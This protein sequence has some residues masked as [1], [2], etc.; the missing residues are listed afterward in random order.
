MLIFRPML[1]LFVLL[2]DD[3]QLMFVMGLRSFDFTIVW[4]LFG[5][6]FIFG[7]LYFRK[8]SYAL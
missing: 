8:E 4:S 3:G 5:L 6:L 7:V 1:G 2:P